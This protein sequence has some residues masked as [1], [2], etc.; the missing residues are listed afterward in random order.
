MGRQI[1]SEKKSRITIKEIA[2][3]LFVMAVIFWVSYTSATGEIETALESNIKGFT[4]VLWS[5]LLEALPFVL[6]GTLISSLIQIYVSE[7][8][9]LKIL[10]KNNFLRLIF[11]SCL[12]LIFPVCECAIIPITR[13]LI[14]KGMPIGPAIAFMIA[15]PIVNPVVLF[16]TYNAFPNMPEMVIY[17]GVFGFLGA[18]IIGFLVGRSSKNVLKANSKADS[19]SCG[20]DHHHGHHG[21]CS[22][23]GHNHKKGKR[24]LL[25][26]LEEVTTH[27]SEEL[28]SVGAYLIFGAII[29]ASMQMFVPKEFLF[30]VGGGRV[31]STITMMALAFVLSLCSEADAFIASTFMLHFTSASVLAFLITG[32]MIDIKNTMMMLGSFKKGFVV[33]LII[34]ILAVCFLLSIVASY[35]IGG[36]NV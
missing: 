9:I 28:K 22:S 24:S 18:I 3:F 6:L 10:P 30:S 27:T 4:L 21:D 8:S 33:R 12:G 35:I 32:P 25:A 5:I 20:H 7:D 19:C 14:K 36:L 34:T 1:L 31:T 11:A 23:H 26:T 17:R 2:V 13:G 15:T 29:A 16:S